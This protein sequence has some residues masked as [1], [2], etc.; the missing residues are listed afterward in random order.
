[1]EMRHK[2]LHQTLAGLEKTK[3]QLIGYDG[4]HFHPSGF[5][6]NQGIYYFIPNIAHFFNISIDSAIMVFYFSWNLTAVSLGLLGFFLLFKTW[7]GKHIALLAFGLLSITIF[8]SHAY[9]YAFQASAVVAT[10]PL[11][12]YFRKA[13]RVSAGFVVF[14]VFAGA[15]LGVSNHL[16]IY[17]GVGPGIF[18]GIILAYS[19]RASWKH[20]G[21]LA[22]AAV[23]GF[24]I[25][26]LYANFL[27]EQRNDYLAAH[28]P[29]PWNITPHPFWHSIYIGF[30]Y[31]DNDLNIHYDDG[32]AN[33]KVLSAAPGTR[34]L[35]QEYYDILRNE[36]F[37]L[38]KEHPFFVLQTIAAKGWK[39][40]LLF[41]MYAN[42]GILAALAY[43]KDRVLDLAFLSGLL[44]QT[45]FGFLVIPKAGYLLGLIAFATIYGVVSINEALE[46]GCMQDGRR[47]LKSWR[48][49]N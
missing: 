5:S 41:L 19:I 14:C 15:W 8:F 38:F 32:V 47:W 17:A 13:G 48:I 18:I 26:T 37:K 9:V 36:V 45:S 20:K 31:L 22:G 39:M 6:D 2:S 21:I 4:A 44:F 28:E 24:M 49:I 3:I 10:I 25:P 29:I 7:T 16:R 46:R 12:L 27:I 34:Y 1:M 11:F 40:A 43:P 30:G 33:A 23:I 42:I 35:S